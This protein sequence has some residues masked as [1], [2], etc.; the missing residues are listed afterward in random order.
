MAAIT[1]IR[2]TPQSPAAAPPQ[3]TLKAAVRGIGVV[4]GGP[5]LL[6]ALEVLGSLSAVGRWPQ[7][8]KYA[9]SRRAAWTLTA[10]GVVAPVID[11]GL[12][13][14]WF[15]RWGSTPAERARR[16]PGDG[17]RRPLIST[18]RAVTVHAPAEE[19]WA[20]LVQIGQ[21]RGGFYSYDWL[22]NLAGCKVTSA[23]TIREEWQHRTTG[24]MLTIFPGYATPLLEVDPPRSLVIANWGAYVVEPIDERSCRLLARARA[25]R[26]VSGL[27]YVLLVELPHAI[28]ERKTMLGIKQRAERSRRSS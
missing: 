8:L 19:V 14:P 17:E 13:R 9:R 21:D 2:T 4:M 5:I 15:R 1:E 24:D 16:L 25:E 23:D 6:D 28:M 10:V 22:E 18:T 20:W 3:P 26:D 12:V 7:H 11:H 27:A